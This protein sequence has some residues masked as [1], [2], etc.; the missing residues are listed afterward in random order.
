M[1]FISP[2]YLSFFFED[3]FVALDE[4]SMAWLWISIGVMATVL[5]YVHKYMEKQED[6]LTLKKK[7]EEEL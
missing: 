4:P 7:Y 3:T 5:M 1:I 2:L 6:K